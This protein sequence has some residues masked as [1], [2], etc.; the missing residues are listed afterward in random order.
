MTENMAQK[1]RED[2]RP[3]GELVA[4][5]GEAKRLRNS[6]NVAEKWIEVARKSDEAGY[7]LSTAESTRDQLEEELSRTALRMDILRSRRE[8]GEARSYEDLDGAARA[9][10]LSDALLTAYCIM[11][12]VPAEAF[13]ADGPDR[14]RY[15]LMGA[16]LAAQEAASADMER[17]VGRQ[18]A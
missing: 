16:L 11:R 1:I 7:L 15:A 4:L 2:R 9:Y 18:P 14:E 13:N 6:L 3:E 10:T 8:L 5:F 12:D 17:C